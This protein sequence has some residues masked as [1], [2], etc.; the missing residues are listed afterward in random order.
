MDRVVS[1]PHPVMFCR[2]TVIVKD[3]KLKRI[4]EGK[5]KKHGEFFFIKI[6][7]GRVFIKIIFIAFLI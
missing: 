5:M 2:K 1:V 3:N 6:I 7:F 4:T